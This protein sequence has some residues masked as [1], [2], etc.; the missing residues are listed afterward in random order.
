M[1]EKFFSVDTRKRHLTTGVALPG[2]L[3]DGLLP[4]PPERLFTPDISATP[5]FGGV[6]YTKNMLDIPVIAR[7]MARTGIFMATEAV[8]L[9][10][11]G[12]YAA[13]VDEDDFFRVEDGQVKYIHPTWPCPVEVLDAWRDFLAGRGS[14]GLLREKMLAFM[15]EVSPAF[16]DPVRGNITEIV[17]PSC[18]RVEAVLKAECRNGV[19]CWRSVGGE[20][21]ETWKEV[22]DV[23]R[24]PAPAQWRALGKRKVD[25]K[26]RPL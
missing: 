12:E 1:S 10:F 19:L 24:I 13:R 15:E 5:S 2:I 3:R 22:F 6:Y 21:G 7:N 8:L 16:S 4:D 18:I 23:L 9:S 25:K 17:P 20:Y 26:F 11:D 14:F